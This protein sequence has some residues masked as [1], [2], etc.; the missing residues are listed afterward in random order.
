MS[1]R[2]AIL[3]DCSKVHIIC[4]VVS[5]LKRDGITHSDLKSQR[6]ILN[7]QFYLCSLKKICYAYHPKAS[8]HTQTCHTSPILTQLIPHKLSHISF[9][10]PDSIP[11]EFLVP[12]SHWMKAPL[13]QTAKSKNLQIRRL[14]QYNHHH[15]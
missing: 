1:C 4:Q 13:R 9:T 15:L 8:V 2:Q 14:C 10:T 11:T 5:S 6:A 12:L 7:E 3:L